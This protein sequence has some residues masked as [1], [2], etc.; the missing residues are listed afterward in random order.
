MARQPSYGSLGKGCQSADAGA[1]VKVAILAS[2]PFQE[3]DDEA[4]CKNR[5]CRSLHEVRT[6]DLL[7]CTLIKDSA[8]N[9]CM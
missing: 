5:S 9:A 6:T 1:G 4:R 7:Q 3:V 8:R 2:G